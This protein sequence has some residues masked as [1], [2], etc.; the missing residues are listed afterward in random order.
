MALRGFVYL[1]VGVMRIRVR[2]IPEFRWEGR[3][4]FDFDDNVCSILISITPL[5][6]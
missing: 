5:H 4:E 6:C 2:G 3:E 1:V